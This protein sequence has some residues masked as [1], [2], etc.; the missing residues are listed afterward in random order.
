MQYFI[1]NYKKS[2]SWKSEISK[3]KNHS[4]KTVYNITKI[5]THL[6]KIFL[7]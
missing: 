7:K 2:L 1:K 3:L 5:I 4:I 6:E